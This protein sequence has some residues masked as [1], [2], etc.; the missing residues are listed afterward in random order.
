MLFHTNIFTRRFYYLENVLLNIDYNE[1]N[2][3]IYQLFGYFTD[4]FVQMQEHRK[5]EA[6][7]LKMTKHRP[8]YYS[9][10]MT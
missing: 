9:H 8:K 7:S 10:M 3:T 4:Y 5:K 1:M 2:T 6:I